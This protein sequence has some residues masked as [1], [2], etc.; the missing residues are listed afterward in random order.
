MGALSPLYP[1]LTGGLLGRLGTWLEGQPSFQPSLTTR[2]LEQKLQA[3]EGS[4]GQQWQ[5]GGGRLAGKQGD[6]QRAQCP[7]V[8]LPLGGKDTGV[9]HLS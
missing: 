6:E 8:K 2:Q 9:Y 1:T 7:R 4:V 3:E 5:R